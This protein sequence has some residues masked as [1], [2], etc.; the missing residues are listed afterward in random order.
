MTPQYNIIKEGKT[1]KKNEI[2][3]CLSLTILHL[4]KLEEL[5]QVFKYWQE[6]SIIMYWIGRAYAVMLFH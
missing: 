3:E 6:K 5:V 2:E 4:L 1:T